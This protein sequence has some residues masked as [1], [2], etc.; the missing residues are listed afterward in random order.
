[1]AISDRSLRRFD[2][3]GL[4][5]ILGIALSLFLYRLGHES[6]W[7]DELYSIWDAQGLPQTFDPE[8][9]L[10]YLLLRVWLIGGKSE[11]WL[12]SFSVLAGLLTVF[13]SYHLA[14]DAMGIAVGRVAAM[15]L[16]LSP[17]FIN[18]TQMVRMYALSTGLCLAGSW[19]MLK[20]LQQPNPPPWRSGLWL[21]MVL[22]VLMLLTTPTTS[23]IL[24]ADLILVLWRFGHSPR[25]LLRWAIAF[26]VIGLAVLPSFWATWEG[27]ANPETITAVE[28]IS[29]SLILGKLRKFTVFPFPM[30]SPV[31]AWLYKGFTLSLWGLI[32]VAVLGRQGQ[33][34][35]YLAVWALLPPLC[36]G[37]LSPGLF[38]TDRYVLFT[39]PYTLILVAAGLVELGRRQRWLGVS[40]ALIYLLAVGS[41]LQR[42]YRVQDR[43]D[44][45][46]MMM[47]IQAQQQPGDI[48]LIGAEHNLE[49]AIAALTYY[50]QDSLPFYGLSQ[51]DCSEIELP[52]N[53]INVQRIWLICDQQPTLTP[54]PK[55][56]FKQ[57]FVNWGFYKEKSY[58]W[59]LRIEPEELGRDWD[60]SP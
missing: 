17:L 49:K 50:H 19:V 5:L 59:L 13:L 22:R 30:P 35:V 52:Q 39:L 33:S 47:T 2:R 27:R 7:I 34:R 21:W 10:Y 9:P 1:M 36:S 8:R 60:E 12:R 46:G 48:V 18:S 23:T 24:V 53:T 28:T 26:G 14:K 44:W 42:Y 58:F 55:Y 51:R 6:L 41:G 37:L 45:R 25:S 54:E 56:S 15:G 40:A 57:K 20:L 31:I 11:V 32:T 38:T 4:V 29:P 3:L 16:T 43:Q